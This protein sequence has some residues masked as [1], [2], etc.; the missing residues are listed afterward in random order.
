[1]AAQKAIAVQGKD[2]ACLV[3][4]SPTP[5]L[6][7]DTI[8]VKAVCVTLNPHDWK[9]VD[10]LDIDGCVVGCD[11]SGVVEDVSRGPVTRQ[12]AVDDH[13]MGTVHGSEYHA[14]ALS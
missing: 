8:L 4:D 7:P 12:F 13:V 2:R 11:F 10:Q 1:M 6:R 9:A 14:A 3:S 5:T